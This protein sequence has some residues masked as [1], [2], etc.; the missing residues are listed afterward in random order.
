MT[1]DDDGQGPMSDAMR[2][3]RTLSVQGGHEHGGEGIWP[4]V[5]PI[6]TS[7]AYATHDPALM[8][9]RQR[10]GEPTYNRDHFPNAERLER[11]VADLEGAESGYATSSGMAAISLVALALLSQGDHVVLGAGGY[12]DTEALL[13]REVQ[14]FGINCTLVDLC[15]ADAVRAA[16]RPKTR[17]LYAETISNP[18]IAVADI[19][20]L[21]DVA[22]ERDIPL[23]IDNTVPSPALCQPIAHGADI[24]VHSVTKFLGGHHDLSAGVIVGEERW[25]G[26]VRR[27]GYLL[28]AVPGAHDAALALRGI[29]TLVPRMAWI[30]HGAQRIAEYLCGR[31]EVASVRYPG[32]LHGTEQVLAAL[33]MP[34]GY[35]GLM[36]V[37]LAGNEA[38][39]V[40]AAFVRSL[41]RIP[42]V[43]SLGGELTTVCYPPRLL[44]VRERE[45][46]DGDRALR[47]SIGL[48]DPDDLIDDMEQAFAAIGRH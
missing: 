48:E 2:R 43:T 9:E 17:M 24:V 4:V 15:D 42:Y 1:P 11:L 26:P 20:M 46:V 8:R 19:P 41:K 34:D 47:F 33:L 29:R 3:L 36:V 12:S 31:P 44:S 22:H 32:L 18:G 35:G 37:E 45:E 27:V 25:I 16:I 7:S 10:R 28:G 13:A 39:D 38:S 40:A 14:R 21:A 5:P 23:V 6:V 30:S